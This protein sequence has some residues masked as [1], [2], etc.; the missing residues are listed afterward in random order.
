MTA[1]SEK[2]FGIM[3]EE[4]IY[5]EQP[6]F[7]MLCIIAEKTLRKQVRHWCNS[8]F[9]LGGKNIELENDIM[10]EIHIRL[11][12]TAVPMFFLKNGVD[13]D[14]NYDPE[15]FNRWMFTL[16]KHLTF[17]YLKKFKSRSTKSIYDEEGKVIEIPDEDVEEDDLDEQQKVLRKSFDIV[18][19]ADIKVYKTLTWLALSLIVLN[20]DMNKIKSTD[21][22]VIILKNKTLFEVRDI[23]YKYSQKITWLAISDGQKEKIERSLSMPYDSDRLWGDV[24]YEECL[25]KKGDK[26]TVSDWANR[27]NNIIKRGLED[28]ASNS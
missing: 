20:H 13:G 23:V 14:L 28:E 4:L 26:K 21:Y 12:K 9:G 25:M 8:D 24:R 22:L 11:I 1:F 27:I 19:A 6:S 2:E 18:L 16:A 15:G 10:Q 17:D 7:E 3:V 5:R